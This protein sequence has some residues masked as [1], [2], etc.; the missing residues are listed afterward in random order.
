MPACESYSIPEKIPYLVCFIMASSTGHIDNMGYPAVVLLNCG[1]YD[2]MW[3]TA[4]T[5]LQLEIGY[6]THTS[7][8]LGSQ[9][10][11]RSSRLL[12][13]NPLR[14]DMMATKEWCPG[15]NALCTVTRLKLVGSM[16]I[17]QDSTPAQ[18]KAA[19]IIIGQ[20]LYIST[21]PLMEAGVCIG[22]FWKNLFTPFSDSPITRNKLPDLRARV[23]ESP[24]NVQAC[25]SAA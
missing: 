18:R 5:A 23:T 7:V 1:L 11:V 16:R 10:D 25:S 12:H 22:S 2:D 8:I 15:V 24:K 9:L 20:R 19:T 21:S 17:E 13:L 4:L 3:S 14:S 6:W